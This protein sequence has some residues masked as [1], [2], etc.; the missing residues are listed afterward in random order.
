MVLVNQR[1]FDVLPH[2]LLFIWSQLDLAHVPELPIITRLIHL[3]SRDGIPQKEFTVAPVLD[4]W[5]DGRNT[6]NGM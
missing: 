1:I 2:L 5:V 4:R 6:K 3:T